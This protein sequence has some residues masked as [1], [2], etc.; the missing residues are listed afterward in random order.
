MATA[1]I[2]DTI[3]AGVGKPRLSPKKARGTIIVKG[4]ARFAVGEIDRLPPLLERTMA[5]TRG[6]A[7]RAACSYAVDIGD[8]NPLRIF[9]EWSGE[10]ALDAHKRSGH[11]AEFS[12]ALAAAKRESIRVD[13]VEGHYLRGLLGET[14]PAED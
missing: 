11:M 9:E 3:S 4:G 6:E 13:A 12:E 1:A 7:A 8:F 5:R 2:D 10:A 14:P